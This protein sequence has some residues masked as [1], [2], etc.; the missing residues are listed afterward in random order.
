MVESTHSSSPNYDKP[1]PEI[2]ADNREF[3]D[4]CKRHEMRLQHCSACGYWRYYPSPICHQCGSFE[5]EWR[6]ITGLGTVYTF[7]VIHH[8]PVPAFSADIPYVY[9]VVELD[10]G[11]MMPTNIIGVASED[12]AIGMR[13]QVTYDDVTPEVTLPKFA[14]V[15]SS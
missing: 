15:E 9:A 13:V 5:V 12:V 6:P 3:W 8:P 11:P 4:S 14:P 1:L 7:S 2:D 10:E